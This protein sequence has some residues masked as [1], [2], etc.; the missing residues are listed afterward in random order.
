ML[1]IVL[2]NL[3][4]KKSIGY[5]KLFE[6]GTAPQSWTVHGWFWRPPWSRIARHYLASIV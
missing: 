5:L 4:K 6:I 2:Y 3:K 1:K